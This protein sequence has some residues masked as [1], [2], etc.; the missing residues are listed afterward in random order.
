MIREGEVL[1]L[2]D[3]RIL[4]KSLACFQ[5]CTRL[6]NS[7]AIYSRAKALN[8]WWIYELYVYVRSFVAVEAKRISKMILIYTYKTAVSLYWFFLGP[9]CCIC[10]LRYRQ[11]NFNQESYRFSMNLRLFMKNTTKRF[12]ET[13]YQDLFHYIFFR[14]PRTSI[15]L[16]V[17]VVVR[18]TPCLLC[19]YKSYIAFS[20][21]SL[22]SKTFTEWL[23]VTVKDTVQCLVNPGSVY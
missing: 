13:I 18:V 19:K 11:T 10:I 8:F 20:R 6:I 22:N 2:G 17:F 9:I 16:S 15:F 4:K 12:Y 23:S 14:K 1:Y 5:V 7:G 21:L 3:L